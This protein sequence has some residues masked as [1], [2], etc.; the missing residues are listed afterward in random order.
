M[1]VYLSYCGAHTTRWSGGDRCNWQNFPRDGD[2]GAAIQAPPGW[3]LVVVDASQIEARICNMLAGQ[4]DVIEKFRK[5]EDIYLNTASL[6]YGFPVTKDNPRERG[7]GKQLELSCQFGA[8]AETIKRT[9]ARGTYGPPVQLTDE[10]AVRAR[11]IYRSTHPGVVNLWQQGNKILRALLNDQIFAVKWHCLHVHHKRIYLPNMAP[12]IYDG[13]Q[14][15]TNEIT[16]EQYWH[17]LH[18]G[19]HVRLYGAK[20]VENI[21]QAL[22]RLQVSQAW[23]RLQ[24]AGIHMVSMEHDKLIACVPEGEADEALCLMQQE[25]CREPDWLPGL[26]LA[27][28]GYIS[29]TFKKEAK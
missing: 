8:G 12:L 18:R 5:G 6:F 22:A 23:L 24:K 3:M 4:N 21:V 16:G 7:T 14:M 13:V 19:H 2:L 9:A 29:H 1:C 26:P 27:S 11:N 20:L 25:M 15:C 28:E 10:D 17:M